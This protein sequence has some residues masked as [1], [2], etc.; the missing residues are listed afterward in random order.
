MTY[1][2]IL[3]N[4]FIDWDFVILADRV[5][6]MKKLLKIFFISL[7]IFALLLFAVEWI[8]WLQENH[9]MRKAG[10]FPPS[11]QRLA[12]HPGVKNFEFDPYTF[13][14]PENGWGRAPE[15][16]QYSDKK[17]VV[18]FGCSYAYGYRLND[19]Q[20]LSYKLANYAKVP[21]YNR[22]WTGWGI[23]H[24]LYQSKIEKI[25]E[26]IPE[27]EYVIYVFLDDHIRRLYLMTFSSWNILIDEQNLR[28]K[29]KDGKLI[30][31][32]NNNPVLRQIKRLYFVNIIHHWYVLKHILNQK[33][34]QNCC[35]FAVK[36]FVEAKNEMQKH[37]KNTKYIVLFYDTK[38][39]YIKEKLEENGYMVINTSD[40]TTENLSSSKYMTD[41]CHPKEA[42]WDLLIPPLSEKLGL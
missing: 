15:G 7:F 19:S 22:A 27:P 18:I 25:Y 21:V 34:K 4:I 32:T 24:M 8:I 31:I 28:Y 41:D 14:R 36:H 2:F 33:N 17:P 13:P 42:V 10:I 29:E 5:F 30:E 9:K 1:T 3:N 40:L 6:N 23:Q 26:Q 39:N 16:L 11:I 38:N 37:W 12:F 20:T 35:N